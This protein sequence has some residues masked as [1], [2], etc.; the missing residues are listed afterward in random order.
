MSI[1][2]ELLH[3]NPNRISAMIDSSIVCNHNVIIGSVPYDE[4]I[5]LGRAMR[6]KTRYLSTVNLIEAVSGDGR[7]VVSRCYCTLRKREPQCKLLDC[8]LHQ[9]SRDR[10]VGFFLMCVRALY[11]RDG[12]VL[13]GFVLF[14]KIRRT[15]PRSIEIRQIYSPRLFY[16]GGG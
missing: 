11:E 16:L 12:A 15:I 4:P 6:R 13:H 7:A 14:T 8:E 3:K 9:S 5:Q 1:E 10:S 2:A